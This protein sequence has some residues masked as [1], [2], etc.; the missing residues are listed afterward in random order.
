MSHGRTLQTPPAMDHSSCSKSHMQNTGEVGCVEKGWPI[1]HGNIGHIQ[2]PWIGEHA[3]HE[4]MDF[5][6]E[7]DKKTVVER[8]GGKQR[9]GPLGW[10]IK[11][12][13]IGHIWRM[14]TAGV[15]W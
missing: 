9:I 10:P 6:R 3:D 15:L 7:K 11:H 2:P 12:G 1:K 5:R 13:N 14:K 4:D 8:M